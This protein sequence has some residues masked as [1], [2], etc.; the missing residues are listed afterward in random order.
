MPH[1]LV[2]QS[3]VVRYF[4]LFF[5]YSYLGWIIEAFYRSFT[6]KRF[7]N[8]GFFTG[9]I[10]P[11]YGFG[12]LLLLFI[13]SYTSGFILP[14]KIIIYFFSL[15]TLEYLTDLALEYIFHLKLWDYSNDYLN[16]QGRVC[17]SFSFA[18]TVLAMLFLL[19]IHPGLYL[20]VLYA[21]ISFLYAFSFLLL[22]YIIIDLTYSVAQISSFYEKLQGLYK[23]RLILSKINIEKLFSPTRRLRRAFPNLNTY[24]FNKINYRIQRSLNWSLKSMEKKFK[25]DLFEKIRNDEGYM[26]IATE[27]LENSEFQRLKEFMHHNS[28]IYDHVMR[29][30]YISYRVS[31]KLKVDY[32]STTRGALLHDFFLYDW[33][34]H[35]IPDLAADIFHG[36]AHPAIALKNAEKNFILNKIERD[37]IIKHMWPLTFK[38][39]RYIES[40]IVNFADKYSASIEYVKKIRTKTK[41]NLQ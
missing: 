38:P 26:E 4:V 11:L 25:G 36:P 30:S 27:I 15:S 40:Y 28:S 7:V 5:V 18:W 34:N 41:K 35:D 10:V 37:I 8:A 13:N 16:F 6:Q 14:I 24:L 3:I 33:R 29:V 19:V 1:L 21:D 22:I 20:L 32:V 12:A 2:E 17:L 23:G 39:P 9:P 31:K